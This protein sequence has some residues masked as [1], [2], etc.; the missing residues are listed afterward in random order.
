MRKTNRFILFYNH[1]HL[2]NYFSVV[3]TLFFVVY[4]T[5]LGIFNSLIWN[6]A[7]SVYY[8]V[9]LII[10]MVC[11]IGKYKSVKKNRDYSIVSFIVCSLFTIVLTLVLIAPAIMMLKDERVVK[12][13]LIPAIAVAAFTTYKMTAAI[14]KYYKYRK[15]KTLFSI[16]TTTFNFISAF[17]SILTLQNT[18]IHVASTSETKDMTTLCLVST[19]L[20]LLFVSLLSIKSM[21]DGIKLYKKEKNTLD[22]IHE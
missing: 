3:A 18:L 22:V 8:F 17:V 6:L 5:Y 14:V 7:I 16:Q 12:L 19:I 10:K 4:N 13:T 15:N 21:M 11:F 9:L 20:I 2:S 1:H